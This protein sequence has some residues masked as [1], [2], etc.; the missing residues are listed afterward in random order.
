MSEP[1]LKKICSC[2]IFIT[3]YLIMSYQYSSSN[4]NVNCPIILLVGKTGS[5][6]STLGNLLLGRDEFFV[7]DSTISSTKKC[8]MASTIINEKMFTIIDTPGIFRTDKTN[9]E[10]PRDMEQAI[11]QCGYGIQAIIVVIEATRFTKEQRDTIDQI[12]KF[13]GKESLNNV[14]AV[15]TKCKK[16][17]TID[18]DLLFNSLVPEQK[19]FLSQFD[20]RFIVSPNPDIFGEPD[21]PIVARHMTKLKNY[22]VG[23]SDLYR[24]DIFEKAHSNRPRENQIYYTLYN[25]YTFVNS[26]K[27]HAIEEKECFAAD[28]KVT[29]RNGK[30]IKISELVIGDYVCCGFENGK[31]V[32][33]EVLLFIHADH[34]SMTEFQLIDFMKQDGSLGTLCTTPEHHI[35]MNNGGT[36][37]AKNVIPN[38]TKLFVSDGEKLVSVT[39]TRITKERRKGYY[40]PLTRS[41]TILVDE[42]LCSCYASAPPYQSLINFAFAPLKIYTKIFPSKHLEKEI[43]P[44]VKFLNKGRGIVEFLDYLN[45]PKKA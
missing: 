20:N 12:I 25:L 30:V 19:E 44:Y 6:K 26:F 34:N 4:D 21:D 43:H 36:G 8:Q 41:G 5:G 28:S 24:I 40:S 1:T 22:I 27:D 38:K 32:F 37:F 42:V 45:F 15:F 35:F 23:F 11:S 9:Q 18:P 10:I 39:T 13:L 31:Q 17:P 29:L 16:A 3:Q 2:D 7:S 33:S 14:I